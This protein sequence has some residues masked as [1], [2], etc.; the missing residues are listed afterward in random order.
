MKKMLLL[1]AVLVCVTALMSGCGTVDSY[2]DRVH[3]YE[4]INDLQARQFV[5]D[6]DYFWLYDR[7]SYLSEYQPH[8]GN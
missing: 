5:D 8:V 4:Q 6:W 1:L 7:N 2:N 3:R